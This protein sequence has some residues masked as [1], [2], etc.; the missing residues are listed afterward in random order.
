MPIP[1]LE[2]LRGRLA[3]FF[4][5]L[6]TVPAGVPAENRESLKHHFVEVESHRLVL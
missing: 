3:P 4:F 2:A 5:F 1:F 6:S